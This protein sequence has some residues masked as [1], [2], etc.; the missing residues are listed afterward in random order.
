MPIKIPATFSSNKQANSSIYMETQR[1]RIAKL[2][3]KR[4]TMLED[5][6]FLTQTYYKATTDVHFAFEISK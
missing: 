3:L 4:T 1:T 5:P 2:I 6:P